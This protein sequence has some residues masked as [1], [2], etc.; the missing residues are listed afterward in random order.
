MCV[1]CVFYVINSLGYISM[2]CVCGEWVIY[3]CLIV[4]HVRYVFVVYVFCVL[5]VGVWYMCCLCLHVQCVWYMCSL[6]VEEVACL[7]FICGVCLVCG[8][9]MWSVF[10]LYMCDYL[11]IMH[12]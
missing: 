4:C 9:Y 7:L 1:V 5:G 3:L 12:C 11:V 10:V 6:C 8:V 2:W